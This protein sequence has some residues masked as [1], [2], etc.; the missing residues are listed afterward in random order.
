MKTKLTSND[1]RWLTSG[2]SV[3]WISLKAGSVRRA[4]SMAVKLYTAITTRA[5]SL[6]VLS[7]S[8]QYQF[9]PQF[10]S[11]VRLFLD[12]RESLSIFGRPDFLTASESAMSDRG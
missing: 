12:L 2:L 6:Q 5:R 11:A 1:P 4:S 3:P 9:F 7:S 10:T 8:I